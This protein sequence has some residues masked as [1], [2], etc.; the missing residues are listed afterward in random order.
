MRIFLIFLLIGVTHEIPNLF[1]KSQEIKTGKASWYSSKDACG[2][3][4]NNIKGCPTASGKSI[5]DLESKKVLFC[6]VPRRSCRLGTR[7]KVTNS[8]NGKSVIVE[9]L[10]TGGFKKYNRA[11]DLGKEA[12]KK[13]ASLEDGVISVKIERVI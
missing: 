12:F 9:V 11:I 8:G 3:K 13:I 1:A 7:L 5:F 2:P 6:A 4:T 10:D